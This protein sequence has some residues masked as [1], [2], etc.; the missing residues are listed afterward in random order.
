MN[1]YEVALWRYWPSMF[2]EWIEEIE[3]FSTHSAM[4]AAMR[5]HG[6]RFVQKAAVGLCKTGSDVL[7]GSCTALWRFYHVVCPRLVEV[8]TDD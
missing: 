4:Y 6:L 3:E 5:L 8:S 1:T 2:P 7:P